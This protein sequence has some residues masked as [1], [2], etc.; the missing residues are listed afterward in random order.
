MQR[1][2]IYYVKRHRVKQPVSGALD[3]NQIIPVTWLCQ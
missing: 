2:H 3:Y 1:D